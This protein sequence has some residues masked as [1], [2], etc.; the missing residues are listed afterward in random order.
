M[1]SN[2]TVGNS[3]RIKQ[4]RRKYTIYATATALQDSDSGPDPVTAQVPGLGRLAKG[5]I[6]GMIGKDIEVPLSPADAINATICSSILL[7][8]YTFNIQ[9]DNAEIQ[10]PDVDPT[11][12][13]YVTTSSGPETAAIT[14]ELVYKPLPSN[15]V[16][17]L[18]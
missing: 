7:F 15:P 6:A 18:P 1:P 3:S 17:H 4:P 5:L 2:Q 16:D 14:V 11:V 9:V 13:P 12:D 10:R 8:G